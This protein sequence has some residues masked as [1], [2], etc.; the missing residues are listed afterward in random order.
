MSA[1][2]LSLRFTGACVLRNGV[3]QN[4]SVAIADGVISKGPL[5]EI[6]L[7]GYLILP[8]IVDL[9]GDG[10]ERQIAPRPRIDFDLATALRATDAEAAANGI[11]TAYL[12]HGWSWEGGKRSPDHAEAFLAA[13]DAYRPQ[14]LT[15][16]RV[17]IRCETHMVETAERL[18]AAVR[19]HKVDYVV[20]N[21]HIDQTL[22]LAET[23]PVLLARLARDA[24]LDPPPYLSRVR[25][26]A[27]QA[28]QVPRFLCRL[29][30]AFDTLGVVYGSHDDH[31]G[32][33]RERYSMIG[34]KVC[35]F[36]TRHAA[37]ALARA[38]GDPIL[39]GAPNVLRGGSQSG[40][41]AATDLI[42]ENLCDALV[43]DYF[44]PALPR[45]AFGL[46]DEGVCDLAAAWAMISAKPAEILRL[47]DRGMIDY[48]KRADL[49]VVNGATRRIEATLAG[50]RIAYLAGE[51]AR[52]FVVAGLPV[53]MAAE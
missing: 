16:L 44:A 5:P 4:R 34:A 41:V 3:L 39:M 22:A 2:P 33:T 6:D 25:A 7:S 45:A 50:G 32:E 49:V 36:P 10:F 24:G 11:T 20:F 9:H 38:V 8:G 17:Q 35:E 53:A 30:D 46:V 31:D 29:A 21:D 28:G 40:N 19:R 27:R 18:I 14:A 26:A 13:L 51:A 52:R 23:D 47:P 43:S 15:D 48:G 37:A 1:A 12:A 42:R